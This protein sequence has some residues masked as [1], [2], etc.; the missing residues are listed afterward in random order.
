MGNIDGCQLKVVV[1]ELMDKPFQRKCVP[2]N[3]TPFS[4]MNVLYSLL[5][6]V[7]GYGIPFPSVLYHEVVA[8]TAVVD[9]DPL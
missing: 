5:H 1:I 4:V 6:V 2:H 8:E 9:N 7:V 3:L